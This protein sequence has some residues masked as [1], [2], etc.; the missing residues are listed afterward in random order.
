MK[1]AEGENDNE[2]KL[3]EA[4]AE[5]REKT[6]FHVLASSRPKE[7]SFEVSSWSTLGNRTREENEIL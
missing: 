2:V 4:C 3:I 6:I 5:N 7:S 1:R